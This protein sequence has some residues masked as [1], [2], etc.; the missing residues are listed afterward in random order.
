MGAP[1][2]RKTSLPAVAPLPSGPKF[3]PKVQGE[4]QARGV[5]SELLTHSGWV[6]RAERF[7]LRLPLKAVLIFPVCRGLRAAAQTP[8]LMKRSLHL[9]SGPPGG[10][11]CLGPGLGGGSKEGPSSPH[12]Q[13]HTGGS[14]PPRPARPHPFVANEIQTPHQSSSTGLTYLIHKAAFP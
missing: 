10:S 9:W 8:C 4:F 12:L 5:L 13:V 7:V 2:S 6:G 3:E 11:S 1:Q 14:T